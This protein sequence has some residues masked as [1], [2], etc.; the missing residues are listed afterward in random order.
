V[1]KVV[2]IVVFRDICNHINYFIFL[3]KFLGSRLPALHTL[4]NSISPKVVCSLFFN[5]CIDNYF[6]F[7]TKFLGSRLPALHT[8]RNSILPKVVCSLSFK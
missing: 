8:L 5:N 4:R 3:T 2:N 6:I 7:L 1:Y